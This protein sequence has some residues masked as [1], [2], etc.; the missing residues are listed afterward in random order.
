MGDMEV[1]F[2]R[3]LGRGLLI[4]LE[5][6]KLEEVPYEQLEVD[7]KLEVVLYEQLEVDDRLELVSYGQLETDDKLELEVDDRLKVVPYEQSEVDDRQVQGGM[8]ELSSYEQGKGLSKSLKAE[9]R[10]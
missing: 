7:D 9:G 6:D 8:Q 4:Q 1:V 3:Q 5:A 2:P 10:V